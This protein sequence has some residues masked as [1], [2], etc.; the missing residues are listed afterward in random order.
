MLSDSELYRAAGVSAVVAIVALIVSGVAL[1]LFFGGAG[2]FW[3]PVNDMVLVVTALALILPMLAVDRLAAEHGVGW[4]RIVT[5]AAILGAL[6]ISIGQTALVLE[7]LSLEGSY[8]TGGVGV[9][10]VLIWLV[11]LV[12]LAFGSGVLPAPIGWA[13]I[14]VLALVVIESAVAAATTGP[15]LWIASVALV[16]ALVAWLWLLSSTLLSRSTA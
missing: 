5:I 13:A 3:G 4:M 10:P 6:L 8:V 14:G 16:V 11:A 1:A 9:I 15:F 7:F 12:V 2:Q